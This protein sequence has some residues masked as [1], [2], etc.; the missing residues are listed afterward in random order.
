M[1]LMNFYE[2]EIKRHSDYYLKPL[3]AKLRRAR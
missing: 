2:N 1:A 3:F